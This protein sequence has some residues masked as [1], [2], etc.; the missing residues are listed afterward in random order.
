M[1]KSITIATL[2]VAFIAGFLIFYRPLQDQTI[3]PGNQSS[4]P[5]GSSQWETK[6][7]EQASVNVSVTPIDLRADSSEWKFDVVM[8]THSVELDQDMTQIVLLT[9][10]DDKEYRPIR[11][12]GPTGGHH[13]EG[14]LIFDPIVPYPQHLTLKIRGI[15]EVDR[16]F[17]W[18][19][20][21]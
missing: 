5:Q 2:A 4:Q 10:D 1:N 3:Q 18:T 12:D 16:N 17:S 11:W 15:G 20:N 13:R 8:D 7:D 21:Q 9:G 14:V 6:S 19:L